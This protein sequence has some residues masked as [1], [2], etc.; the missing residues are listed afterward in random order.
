MI[1]GIYQKC[2]IA[3]GLTSLTAT[4]YYIN[5]RIISR[6]QTTLSVS[7]AI[8]VAQSET[9]S[10][11]SGTLVE[12]ECLPKSDISFTTRLRNDRYCVEWDVKLLLLYHTV[13]FTKIRNF[14]GTLVRSDAQ[15]TSLDFCNVCS[16]TIETISFTGQMPVLTP[17]MAH[18]FFTA[19][20][21]AKARSLPSS[22]VRL[23][24]R[25]IVSRRLKI[26]SHF[27]FGPVGQSFQVFLIPCADTQF[28][29][30]P[31]Q[32]GRIIHWV[33]KFCDFRLKWPF[34]T[35]TVRDWPLIAMER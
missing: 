28:R 13:W 12:R 32:R 4:L 19:R 21:Y 17:S 9:N 5:S 20:R 18:M 24:R 15:R 2:T 35:E 16:R 22:G 33:W 31:L 34:I 26:S 29:A 11:Y 3:V 8:A 14:T 1:N 6:N 10:E 23:T 7:V 30:E 25:Q 27:L